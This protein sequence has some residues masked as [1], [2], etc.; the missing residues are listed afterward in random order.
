MNK[1][2][3]LI[4][5]SEDFNSKYSILKDICTYKVRDVRFGTSF[6]TGISV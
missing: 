1:F 5:N 3:L 2:T 6:R 4:M